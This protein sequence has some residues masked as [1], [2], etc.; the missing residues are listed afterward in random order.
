[1]L[2]QRQ[3][4]AIVPGN[5]H[6]E[7]PMYDVIAVAEGKVL[8]LRGN[9]RTVLDFIARGGYR[10]VADLQGRKLHSYRAL[11]SFFNTVRQNETLY[12]IQDS[13]DFT[14]LM[15]HLKE[16]VDRRVSAMEVEEEL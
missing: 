16:K 1:M 2:E 6:R 14:L 5:E 15:A 3:S 11:P 7:G 10:Q 13:H 8:E 4:T 12:L 9:Q